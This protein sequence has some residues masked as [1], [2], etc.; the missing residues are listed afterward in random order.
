MR[1]PRVRRRQIATAPLPLPVVRDPV[2]AHRCLSPRAQGTSPLAGPDGG[3][4][5][6]RHPPPT[7]GP[8]EVYRDGGVS[9][10]VMTRRP[11]TGAGSALL[12][13]LSAGSTESAIG[14]F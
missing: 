2:S 4:A 1:I 12:L 3:G 5:G 8:G 6:R 7:A 10:A 9:D 11:K 13:A 14:R